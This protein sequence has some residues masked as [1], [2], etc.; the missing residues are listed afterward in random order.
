MNWDFGV[1]SQWRLLLYFW[2]WSRYSIN[3]M[4]LLVACITGLKPVYIN[5]F[6]NNWWHLTLRNGKRKQWYIFPTLLLAT[7]ATVLWSGR[8]SRATPHPLPHCH[9]LLVY[10]LQRADFSRDQHHHHQHLDLAVA[11]TCCLCS[12]RLVELFEGSFHS[13]YIIKNKWHIFVTCEYWQTLVKC[14]LNRS[15][16]I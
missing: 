11:L 5:R 2:T 9:W 14:L 16:K 6:I 10:H 1:C 12:I 13:K 15:I 8:P 3:S 7:C 4:N